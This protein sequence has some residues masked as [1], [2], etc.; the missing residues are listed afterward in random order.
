M[1]LTE[2]FKV[3]GLSWFRI[4]F[5][6]NEGMAFGLTF[7]GETGKVLLTLL[8]IVAV[9]FIGFYLHKLWRQRAHPGF[10]FSMALI[11]AGALGNIIDSVFYGVL[12]SA[13]TWPGT[14]VATFLPEG[15]GYA[16]LL[17]GKVVDMFFF[18]LF[19]GTFPTW[20]PF[21]G[22]DTFLFFRP[23]FNLA[24]SY[25]TIGVILI[26]LFQKKFFPKKIS[27]TGKEALEV[28]PA[29]EN[30]ASS[31]YTSHGNQ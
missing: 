1:Y 29:P 3:L 22:G 8:R 24:D 20:L 4:H 9:I 10:I 11:F 12:F 7:G 31:S 18:P 5:I 2:E 13:S 25:I 15:G 30:E 14:Q 23:V 6:E 28:N 19:H 21:V 27:D 16:G 26:L 17:H